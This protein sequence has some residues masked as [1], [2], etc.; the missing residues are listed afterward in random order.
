MRVEVRDPNVLPLLDESGEVH[1]LEKLEADVI[2]FALG[3]YRGQ[4]SAMARK[5]GIGRS[6]LYRK[7]KEYGPLRRRSAGERRGGGVAKARHLGVVTADAV[8]E[9]LVAGESRAAPKPADAIDFFR[10][11]DHVTMR[12]TNPGGGGGCAGRCS[13][14]EGPWTRV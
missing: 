4:M 11:D 12:C 14:P 13:R 7:M 5:L 9:H 10:G 6:T 2:R 1:R 8:P 3:H